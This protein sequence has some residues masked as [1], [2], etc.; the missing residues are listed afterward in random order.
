M[1]KYI[2][3]TILGKNHWLLLVFVGLPSLLFA[4]D[5]SQNWVKSI[6]YKIQSNIP[7]PDPGAV[8]AQVNVT[9]LDG[10][11]RPIQQIANKQAANG[12]DIIT[13]LAY[14]AF[15]R[16]DKQYLPYVSESNSMAF[17]ADA[18][19][20]VLQ[21]S[22]YVGQNPF[23][24]T[25]Y[26]DSP[27]NRM[28]KIAAPGTTDNWALGSGNEIGFDYQANTTADLVK[29]F[30][31]NN[32]VLTQNGIFADNTLYKTITT[33]ENQHQTIVFKNIRGQEVLKRVV[34]G[35]DLLDTYTVYDVY[36]NLAFVVP[37]LADTPTDASQ[38]E[39]LCYQYKYDYRNRL[40]EK[41]TPGKQWEYIVYDMLNRVVATG[42]AHSPFGSDDAVQGWLYTQYDIYSRV[43]YTGWFA[44]SF[45]TNSATNSALRVT[46]QNNYTGGVTNAERA[47]GQTLD[48]I[49][50]GYT[51]TGAP[52]GLLLLTVNY[53]D[54]YEYPN[55]PTDFSS[56]NQGLAI[57]YNLEK[58][59]L[60]LATG[61]WVRVLNSTATPVVGET[62]Y[63]MYD[64]RGRPILSHKTNSLGGFTHIETE[65]D[66]AGMPKAVVT[67]NKRNNDAAT[68]TIYTKDIYSYTNQG[69]LD[70]HLHQKE[71][72]G[73]L[74]RLSQNHYT[75]LGQISNKFVG[76]AL[77]GAFLQKVDYTYNIRGWLLGINDIADLDEK[78]EYH[79]NDLFALKLN[80][81]TTEA[82]EG[83]ENIKGLYNGAISET[84]WRSASDNIVR[85]YGYIYDQANR[86]LEAIY[87]KPGLALATNAYNE[88]IAYDNNG[89]ITHIQRNGN[90]DFWASEPFEID[91]L[92]YHYMESEK[93]NQLKRVYD[94]STC[95]Q[96][97]KDNY[98][99]TETDTDE[100]Y[101]YDANGNI[102]YDRNKSITHIYYN[103][104]NLPTKIEFNYANGG[105]YKIDYIYNAQGEKVK[106]VVQANL[107]TRTTDYIDGFQYKQGILQFYPTSEGYVDNTY[108]TGANKYNYVYQYKDQLGNI[109]LS[110]SKDPESGTTKI[111]EENHYY[112]YGLKHTN[113]NDDL[114]AIQGKDTNAD[115]VPD[116]AAMKGV[117]ID[118]SL[119][120]DTPNK[121]KFNGQEWQDELGLNITAMDYRQ[122]DNA[123]GR[124]GNIDKLCE[125][126][127]EQS[128]YHFANNN[129][130]LFSD[131]SGLDGVGGES[132][133]QS[134]GSYYSTPFNGAGANFSGQ[135]GG[136][137]QPVA[138]QDFGGGNP[139]ENG[140]IFWGS[141]SS[142]LQQSVVG[143]H[144]VS[145]YSYTQYGSGNGAD[146]LKTVVIVK[147]GWLKNEEQPKY[148]FDAN[149]ALQMARNINV[150]IGDFGNKIVASG[151][152]LSVFGVPEVGA[153]M[154]IVGSQLSAGSMLTNHAF[155][156]L[157]D[158]KFNFSKAIKD[159][160]FY[161][162][163]KM[164]KNEFGEGF[165]YLLFEMGANASDQWIDFMNEKQ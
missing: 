142:Q 106:K 114:Y 157:I 72:N 124:F 102:T 63:L 33:D 126:N 119:L 51:T 27:L 26:E 28:L 90:A 12:N 45:G 89:N 133:S 138:A 31:A 62:T 15:G 94:H 7:I 57:Y 58:K 16:Q 111:L 165:D 146:L 4:Q 83:A 8:Q 24:Q 154:M 97:F 155:D 65:I 71:E 44:Q 135:Y 86:L 81:D 147:G 20:T 118:G 121:F 84:Y 69:R 36:D 161:T 42:P 38:M 73:P 100:D 122:Y 68:T 120:A 113:Y 99:A 34:N 116:V 46:L 55:A 14:D 25:V 98:G 82:A 70:K 109:R 41:K 93:S 29:L 137:I 87:Q 32:N 112:P 75:E 139:R 23:S 158:H 143:K 160:A 105:I 150:A 110:Y 104:L 49:A 66:F 96:G 6:T 35:T 103:H 131:P 48:G 117:P 60:G 91:N 152:G 115:T 132:W 47:T 56:A 39:S 153:P 130:V 159:A 9:Y 85:K 162:V 79:P 151:F 128:P 95:P 19:N 164:Y 11:G 149:I 22:E 80:Y 67:R 127:F 54:D 108:I 59:P 30:I 77:T 2:H 43:A 123:I 17:D 140:G 125:A 156:I 61:S 92:E 74:E 52:A 148:V 21:Y 64:Y 88:T 101:K 107:V 76:G 37:P 78:E 18:I 136:L 3:T 144:W 50:I 163:P 1:K 141:Y 5:N 13:P 134:F 40:V 10:F 145:G 129:P 53:Y